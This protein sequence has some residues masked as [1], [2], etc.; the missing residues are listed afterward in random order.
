MLDSQE[1][2]FYNPKILDHRINFLDLGTNFLKLIDDAIIDGK[3]LG[4]DYISYHLFN[5]VCTQR[6]F[7]NFVQYVSEF[8]TTLK[9]KDHPNLLDNL[10]NVIIILSEPEINKN[11]DE[12]KNRLNLVWR[13]I[14]ENNHELKNNSHFKKYLL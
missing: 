5:N 9:E 3:T 14:V 6:I 1:L 13:E 11:N 4:I 8:C 12:Y 7:I 10:C 2:D